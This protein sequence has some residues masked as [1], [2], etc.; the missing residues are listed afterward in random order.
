MCILIKLVFPPLTARRL[1]ETRGGLIIR[2][3]CVLLQPK[4]IYVALASVLQTNSDLEFIGVMVEV[5]QLVCTNFPSLMFLLFVFFRSAFRFFSRA[6]ANSHQNF[7]VAR[8]SSNGH[9]VVRG[10]RVYDDTV[11]GVSSYRHRQESC[12]TGTTR[13]PSV[14]LGVAHTAPAVASA[15]L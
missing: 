5:R 14:P 11:F 3:L 1:L 12:R 15:A 2:R 13:P 10:I 6:L 9:C 8:D 4:T 7:N